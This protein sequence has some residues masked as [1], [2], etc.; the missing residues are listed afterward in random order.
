MHFPTRFKSRDHNKEKKRQSSTNATQEIDPWAETSKYLAMRDEM[1]V[2]ESMTAAVQRKTLLDERTNDTSCSCSDSTSYTRKEN[3]NRWEQLLTDA[4]FLC[5]AQNDI[6]FTSQGAACKSIANFTEFSVAT[7]AAHARSKR[8]IQV[9]TVTDP[10]VETQDRSESDRQLDDARDD[11]EIRNTT[12]S[13]RTKKSSEDL[14]VIVKVIDINATRQQIDTLQP[15]TNGIKSGSLV[16]TG[17]NKE[18][19]HNKSHKSKSKA[20]QK[21]ASS[22]DKSDTTG[23]TSKVQQYNTK[24]IS[25]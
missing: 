22:H 18:V 5:S 13:S 7:D 10:S 14:E 12:N 1:Y 17:I 9:P 21:S 4:F 8:F 3:E 16:V 23:S 6:C 19:F 25:H 11:R 20:K 2:K 24:R 15:S